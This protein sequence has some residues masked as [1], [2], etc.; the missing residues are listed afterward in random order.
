VI[1]WHKDLRKDFGGAPGMWAYSESPLVDGDAVICTP[2]G[3]TATMVKLNKKDGQTIWTCAVAAGDQAG[4]ASPIKIDAAGHKQYVTFMSK[5]L[6]GV[7][8]E[9]GKFLWRYDQTGK[10]PANIPTP[11]AH[12]GMIYT[13]A[14]RFGGGLV[15]LKAEG[16]GIQAQQVYYERGLPSNIGGAVLIGENLYGT[17]G[18]G[19]ACVDFA[20]GKIK[21]QEGTLGACSVCYAD[22]CLYLHGETGKVSLVEASPDGYHNKGTFLPPD[23]PKHARG[24][25]ERSWCYPVVANG[26]LYIRD[27]DSLWCFDVKAK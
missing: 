11:I 27:S 15:R 9:T 5:G 19:L 21:W 12:D 2:G 22:G 23:M 13:A 14:S 10:G 4:Y 7:D 6:V 8:A 3:K 25:M 26:K 16:D 20:T 1:R 17:I 18:K 24:A